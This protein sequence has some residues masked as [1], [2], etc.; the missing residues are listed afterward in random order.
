MNLGI[1]HLV[2][3]VLILKILLDPPSYVRGS[4]IVSVIC[5][6][7]EQ[8]IVETIGDKQADFQLE[9]RNINHLEE[10]MLN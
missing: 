10:R 9:N 3:L 6:R 2:S 7:T 5:R 4:T 1:N 8:G